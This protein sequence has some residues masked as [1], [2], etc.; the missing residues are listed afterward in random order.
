MQLKTIYL[1]GAIDFA[2]HGTKSMYIDLT[3]KLLELSLLNENFKPIY[4]YIPH[5]HCRPDYIDDIYKINDKNLIESDLLLA[6][7]GQPSTGTG[8][9]IARAFE[10]GKKIVLF[11]LDNEKISSQLSGFIKNNNIPF[12]S[13]NNYNEPD[14]NRIYDIIIRELGN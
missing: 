11:T 7:I 5:I 2:R 4:F 9:E 6:Y 13:S 8:F 10:L 1:A 14:Y 3:R 12:I